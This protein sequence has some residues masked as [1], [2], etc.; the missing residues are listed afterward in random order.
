[1]GLLCRDTFPDFVIGF[2]IVGQ[3]DLGE[4]LIQFVQQMQAIADKTKFFFHAGETSKLKNKNHSIL[5]YR[6]S[7]IALKQSLD[8]QQYSCLTSS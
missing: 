6:M 7:F 2:D 5:M 3:E 1:L 4:P 8:P